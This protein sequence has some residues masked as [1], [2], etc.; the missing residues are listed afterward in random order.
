M[1]NS[2]SRRIVGVLFSITLMTLILTSH[3]FS[4]FAGEVLLS[5]FEGDLST[6]ID[7]DPN[8]GPWEE[9]H[10][11]PGDLTFVTGAENG[12]SEG[13]QALKIEHIKFQSIPIGIRS[14]AVGDLQPTFDANTQIRA[15]F[16]V[17]TTSNTREVFFRLQLNGGNDTID[18]QDMIIVDTGFL[19]GVEP[20]ETITGIW[21]Y[22]AEGILNQI[23]SFEPLSGFWL[24]L[25]MRGD[26]PG[27]G[28][29]FTTV[30]NIRWCDA[31]PG[32]LDC[33][34]DVDGGDFLY[35]QRGG[36]VFSNDTFDPGQTAALGDWQANYDPVA[37][38]SAV[39]TAVPEPGSALLCLVS[40]SI[41]AIRQRARCSGEPRLPRNTLKKGTILWGESSRRSIACCAS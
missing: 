13:S 1:I 11:I 33:D 6:S 5:G 17:P 22:A 23:A 35:W 27:G 2:V 4:S 10:A 32:D 26:N 16:T 39:S 40:L 19:P 18:G 24:E 12:V 21:D 36:F 31:E 7:P 30:D 41:L 37:P 14:L 8:V 25:G 34:G 15:E 38:L 9:V 29:V 28:T 3:P 20:G